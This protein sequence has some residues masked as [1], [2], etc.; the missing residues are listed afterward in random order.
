[1]KKIIALTFIVFSA[2]IFSQ[3]NTDPLSVV[4][5]RMDS[6]NRHDLTA[7]LN[8]YAEDVQVFTYPNIPLG[9]KGKEHLKSIFEPM[10]KE[11]KVSV[12]IINQIVQGQHIINHEVVSYNGKDQKYVSI[13]EVENGLIRTVQFI[14]E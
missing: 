5:S 4:N 14:R 13:Y 8:N 6:Y 1:M 11:A 10:F 9:N 3:E 7:F 2:S 12:K